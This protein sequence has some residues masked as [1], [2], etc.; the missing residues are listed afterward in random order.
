MRAR[1]SGENAL[2]AG[3]AWL[4]PVVVAVVA[5]PV[6]VRG[7]GDDGY[8][9]L[10]LVSAVTGYLGLID[11]GLGNGILRYLSMFIA[12]GHGRTVRECARDSLLWFTAGGAI[13]AVTVY[14]L[15]PWLVTS[16]LDVPAALVPEAI[17]AFQLGG[18]AFGLGMI[19]AALQFIPQSF[20]RYGAVAVLNVTLGSAS[21]AGPAVLVLLGYGLVPIMWFGVAINALAVL[22]WAL[23]SVRLLGQV[24]HEGPPFRE[25]WREFLT[26][27]AASAA[28]R[29]WTVI[30]IQTSKTV[31]GIA[32][33]TAQ[34]AYFQVPT[35]LSDKVNALLGNM[36][37]VLLPTA[38]QLV[39]E[40]KRD[41]LV[42]LY[43]TSSRLLYLLNASATAAVMVFAA[44]LL[45]YWV[46]ARYADQGAMAL[47]L[48]TL[49]AA[50]S[51]TTMSASRL[52][53][54]LGR[55]YVNLAF[56]FINSLVNLGTVYFLTVA[57]GITGTAL[58]GLVAAAIAP[59]FLHYTH[60]RVIHVSNAH[61]LR[62]CY[63]RGTI[64]V[65]A[66]AVASY[67]L[68]LPFA[69]NLIV[70]VLLA[71]VC[72]AAGLGVSAAIG[73]VFPSDW[74]ALRTALRRGRPT[75]GGPA[76]D[77]AGDTDAEEEVS[78]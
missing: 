58:S 22:A 23:V 18:A 43:K 53:L 55:P 44:P 12:R 34:A 49:S 3:V 5:V 56:S 42:E 35:V 19:V 17:V 75:A 66:A 13:G 39:A 4:I 14:L 78:R 47:A 76:D 29:I 7:L 26:F 40:G 31:V 61:V 41:R 64:G 68:L 57:Y 77:T 20:L 15:S 27:S 48:L 50:L 11:L 70:T 36:S 9:V 38:A 32:R 71:G 33:G 10:A 72:V 37:S 59:V 24:A 8:G 51:A 60:S 46:G 21:V 52:N 2:L 74:E 62:D 16:V 63:L 73:A 54:A 25:Y 28:N 67:F 1:G 45:R 69:T 6:T 30:Q 65:T